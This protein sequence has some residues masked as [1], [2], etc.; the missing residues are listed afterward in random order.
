MKNLKTVF[1]IV[2]ALLLLNSNSFAQKAQTSSGNSVEEGTIIIDGFY[3]FPYFNGSA[4][5]ALFSNTVGNVRNTNH[6]GAKVE[7]MVTDAIGLGVEFTYANAT[8]SYRDSLYRTYTAGISK[9]RVLGKMNYHF[10]TDENMDPYLTF[11]AGIKQTTFYDNSTNG[12]KWTGFLFP[13]AIRVGVGMRYFFTDVVGV[14]AEV[15]LGGP[16]MQAGVSFRF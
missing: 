1:A 8:V 6:L 14:N 2:T 16:L 9:L 4:L 13:V 3:G 10:A 15:G 5:R 11:G 7:Y 12:V